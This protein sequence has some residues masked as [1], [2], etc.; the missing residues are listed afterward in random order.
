M[1]CPKRMCGG[2]QGGKALGALRWQREAEKFPEAEAGVW[3][4][5]E[6]TMEATVSA[7][8]ALTLLSS[9]WHFCSSVYK[10]AV[11]QLQRNQVGSQGSMS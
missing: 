6:P 1:W 5:S 3:R 7:E 4:R 9:E 8:P 11:A 2:L 10:L